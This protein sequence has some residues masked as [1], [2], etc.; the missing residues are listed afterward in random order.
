MLRLEEVRRQTGSV[1]KEYVREQIEK[2]NPR[3][4]RQ[5]K[6]R[7]FLIKLLDAGGD[8]TLL[9][10]WLSALGDDAIVL[11]MPEDLLLAYFGAPVSREAI[12]F[13]GK[14]AD[15]WTIAHKPG[16]IEKVTVADGKVV[17]V[18]E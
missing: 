8:P 2:L 11:G 7:N 10:H 16:R 17:H 18:R 15:L 3:E 6:T 1:S 12:E 14:P 4:P 5:L 13:R 9:D